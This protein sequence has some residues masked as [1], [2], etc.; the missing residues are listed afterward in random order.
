MNLLIR[1]SLAALLLLILA[2]PVIVQGVTRAGLSGFVLDEAGQPLP[3]ANVVA[4][5]EP[6]GTTYGTAT[7]NG[8]AFLIPNMRV[9]G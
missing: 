1:T 5:H 8:G 4:V 2:V 7:R 9:G 6:S 3:G